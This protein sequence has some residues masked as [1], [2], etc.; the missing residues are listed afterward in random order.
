MTKILGKPCEFQ[1]VEE[2]AE[3]GRWAFVALHGMAPGP[4]V[5]RYE[6]WQAS[7]AQLLAADPEQLA[8]GRWVF[9]ASGAPRARSHCRFVLLLTHFLPDSLTYSVP[10]SLKR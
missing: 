6:D 8:L 7:N 4:V 5:A 1:V 2:G 3:E 10:L 9:P